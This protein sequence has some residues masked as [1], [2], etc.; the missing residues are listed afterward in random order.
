C[1]SWC[2]AASCA[3]VVR[4][5]RSSS[6]A[7]ATTGSWKRPR[8]VSMSTALAERISQEHAAVASALPTQVVSLE[9]RREL[10]AQL[11]SVGLPTVRDDN[12]KY[13]NLR[14]LERVKFTP[15]SERTRTDVTASDLPA[16]L[17][18][19]SRYVFLDGRFAPQ[20]SRENGKPGVKMCTL[21]TISRAGQAPSSFH[22]DARFA[23]LNE[24]FVLDGAWISVA[25]NTECL[26]CI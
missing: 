8:E 9:R 21:R 6:S 19:Y 11:A 7:T 3:R 20:L 23:W 10:L 17:E 12:W 24:A 14:P 4:S 15:A 1:T 2:A 22:P 5:S 18:G 13:A 26:A 16:A 25:P